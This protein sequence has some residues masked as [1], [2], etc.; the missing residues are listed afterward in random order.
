MTIPQ[1]MDT[2]DMTIPQLTDTWD[3]T[4]PQLHGITEPLP[5]HLCRHPFRVTCKN[6]FIFQSNHIITFEVHMPIIQ[7]NKHIYI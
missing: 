4:I 1:L 3:K 5:T 6:K 2:W 7:T